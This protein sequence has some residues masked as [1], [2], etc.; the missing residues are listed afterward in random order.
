MDETNILLLAVYGSV[1]TI[2]FVCTALAYKMQTTR[3]S[4]S[5]EYTTL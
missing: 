3:T 4:V 2:L 5:T 1:L